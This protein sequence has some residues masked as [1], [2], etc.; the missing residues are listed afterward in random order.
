MIT[1]TPEMLTHMNGDGE[2]D[3]RWNGEP[4]ELMGPLV[5][6]SKILHLGKR[7]VARIKGTRGRM[8]VYGTVV[9]KERVGPAD[10]NYLVDCEVTRKLCRCGMPQLV[11]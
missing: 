6:D 2:A 11:E 9:G 5:G 3:F 4:Y 10:Y 7:V 8:I 1:V